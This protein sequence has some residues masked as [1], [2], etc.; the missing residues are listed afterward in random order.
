MSPSM[1]SRQ[2]DPSAEAPAHRADPPGHVRTC[3]QVGDGGVEVA[4]YGVHVAHCSLHQRDILI[5]ARAGLARVQVRGERHVSLGREVVGDLPDAIDEA[6]PL[7]DDHKRGK[8]AGSFRDREVAAGRV[9]AVQVRDVDALQLASLADDRRWHLAGC[10]RRDRHSGS[11][12][13]GGQ[14]TA[15]IFGR[16][17]AREQREG[18]HD[19]EKLHA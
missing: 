10:G 17:P 13:R 2:R 14:A 3:L 8:G 12:H 9:I 6:V 18:G 4:D 15:L 19:G 16:C 1:R 5:G 11:F 7:V